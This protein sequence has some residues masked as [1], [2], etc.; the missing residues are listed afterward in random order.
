MA[1]KPPV[2]DTNSR[3]R[4][5][6]RSEVG[7]IH[8][9]EIDACEGFADPTP[10]IGRRRVEA[11]LCERHVHLEFDFVCDQA[12][13]AVLELNPDLSGT[14]RSDT[15]VEGLLDAGKG[16]CTLMGYAW[17]VLVAH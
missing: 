9:I 12:R 8:L 17:A 3:S 1:R 16:A 13:L 11:P 7:D 6:S 15:T 2:A 4:A 14:G 5:K 10:E